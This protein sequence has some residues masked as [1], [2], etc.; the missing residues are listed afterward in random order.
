M[1]PPHDDASLRYLLEVI[2]NSSYDTLKKSCIVYYL[3]KWY[4]DGSEEKYREERGIPPQFAALADAYWHLDSGIN[5]PV[6]LIISQRLVS[7]DIG[8]T[9]CR[10]SFVRPSIKQRSF[11]QN[12]TSYI[13]FSQL[14]ATYP[15]ICAECETS[16]DRTS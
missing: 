9:A 10:C 12:H 3:L 8:C 11:L 1:Y 4:Q 5:V 2:D 13:T 14:G 15:Q 6:S 7:P 16:V